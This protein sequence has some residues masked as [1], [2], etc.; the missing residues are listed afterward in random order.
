M[1]SPEDP[2]ARLTELAR[3]EPDRTA[4]ICPNTGQSISVA[5]LEEDSDLLARGLLASGVGPGSRVA[6]FVPSGRDFLSLAFALLKIG[7]VAVV[8]D[9][10]L[11]RRRLAESLDRI[12]PLTYVG[13]PS[14]QLGRLLPGRGRRGTRTSAAE[15]RAA[16]A[17]VALPRPDPAGPAMVA[18]CP[19]G[20]AA[21]Y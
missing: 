6:L 1:A 18:I 5:G 13:G 8:V 15:L 9:P 4:L 10:S 2:A 7:A 11:S 17:P 21:L 19:G 16:A 20:T 3:A 14:V 12:G